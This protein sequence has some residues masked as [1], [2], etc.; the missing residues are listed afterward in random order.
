MHFLL[1]QQDY[2]SAHYGPPY[3]QQG[4]SN[5]SNF[6]TNTGA[7]HLLNPYVTNNTT[8]GSSHSPGS[9]FLGNKSM[10]PLY[11]VHVR[12]SPISPATSGISVKNY[13]Y[14]QPNNTSLDYVP[15]SAFCQD[16]NGF[17]V[18]NYS[19]YVNGVKKAANGQH[20]V[21][22]PPAVHQ[23]PSVTTSISSAGTKSS[24]SLAT[25]V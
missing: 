14:F 18:D 9:P 2:S 4:S 12:A 5:Y 8:A 21:V 16:F 15:A 6:P 22:V 3:Q 1:Q 20:D 13:G 11:S 25:H 7:N 24:G 17:N 19:V 10:D 23:R